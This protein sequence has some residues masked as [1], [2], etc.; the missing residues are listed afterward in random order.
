M[1]ATGK[2][3]TPAETLRAWCGYCIQST[4]RAEIENCGGYLVYATGR[5]CEF[6][7]YRLGKR[8]PM[9]V[10]RQFCLSCMGGSAALVR[11]CHTYS[12]PLHLYRFGKNPNIR[13]SSKDH[14][15]AIRAPGSTFAAVK[16]RQ[17]G[18]SP[19][20]AVEGSGARGPKP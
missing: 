1:T 14:L 8:P 13:G 15:D 19:A 20:G 5:P 12:C 3:R 9:K 11:E 16:L 6:Y 7:A 4:R 10:F 18:R 2:R 17:D